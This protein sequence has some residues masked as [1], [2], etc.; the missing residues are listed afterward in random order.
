MDFMQNYRL[1]RDNKFFDNATRNYLMNLDEEKDLKEI[2]DRFYKELEFGTAGLRGVMGVGTNRMNQYTVGKATVGY[3]KYLL[4]TYGEKACAEKG[5]VV[6][7]DTR[8]NSYYF[9]NLTAK[10]FTS[11]GIKVFMLI[12][13]SPIPVMSCTIRQLNAVGGVVI[14]AS[15]NP[16]EYNGYKVYDET[17][18]QLGVEGSNKVTDFINKIKS[19]EEIDFEGNDDLIYKVRII[20]DFVDEISKQSLL[21]NVSGKEDLKIVFT[22]LHGTGLVPVC[23]VLEKNGFKNV[24]IV[25]EQKEPNGDFP[26]VP[27]PNPGDKN[28]LKMGIELA[29]KINADIVIGTDPDSD[30]I[31][32]AVKSNGEFNLLTGNQ[33]GALLIDYILSNKDLSDL[34]NPVIIKSIVTSNLGSDIAKKKSVKT[35]QTL[36]GFKFIGERMNQFEEAKKIGDSA[37]NYD[38]IFGYE[39]SYGFLCGTHARDKDAVVS[40]LLI[41]EMS[42]K[43]K[44]LGYNMLDRLNEIYEEFGYYYDTQVS[45]VFKGKEDSEKIGK[46]MEQLRNGKVPFTEKSEVI[47]YKKGVKAEEGFGMLPTAN[48]LFYV[49]EDESWIAVRPSGTEPLIKFYYSIKGKSH[50]DAVT[51]Q[52][53]L[54]SELYKELNL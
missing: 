12:T 15:H 27:S 1:W 21:S 36:T 28:A 25:E 16:K 41:C 49:L 45:L 20:E 29:N 18:C 51:R 5:V 11:F 30:R 10:I 34:N 19:Y 22:P 43:Y 39:E 32:V 17:G 7:Y 23:R 9:A 46:I 50:E 3:A 40:A 31:G 13:G 35:L 37:K 24:T 33:I 54:Q 44:K 8:N 53:K 2:E 14:T 52:Q 47:D 26:T 6:D 38:F 4:E 42:A 48:V